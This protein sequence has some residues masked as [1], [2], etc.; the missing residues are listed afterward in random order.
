MTG[1]PEPPGDRMQPAADLTELRAALSERSRADHAAVR[2]RAASRVATAVRALPPDLVG[3]PFLAALAPHRFSR[4][5]FLDALHRL[6]APSPRSSPAV[7]LAATLR[8]GAH[9]DLRALLERVPGRPHLR[10]VLEEL[11]LL[12]AARAL[13]WALDLCQTRGLGELA[14]LLA[15]TA[16]HQRLALPLRRRCLGLARQLGA[17]SP[18]LEPELEHLLRG[19][20]EL[21]LD[22]ARMAV[23][24]PA[25][26]PLVADLLG[27]AVTSGGDRAQALAWLALTPALPRPM[28]REVLAF[29]AAN[30]PAGLWAA[31]GDQ[32]RADL[33]EHLGAALVRR[34][35]TAGGSRRVQLLRLAMPVS[36]QRVAAACLDLIRG[37]DPA[38]L[39]PATALLGACGGASDLAELD[40]LGRR[41][42]SPGPVRAAARHAAV[43]IRERTAERGG[44]LSVVHEGGLALHSQPGADP[45][46]LALEPRTDRGRGAPSIPRTDP[47]G[48]TNGSG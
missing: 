18:A 43:A 16:R 12:A 33:D 46:G 21:A 20:P 35:A 2:D 39:D 32:V 15:H 14:P 25:L 4:P 29:A 31:I 8:D 37:G 24:M 10:Q 47:G 34:A 42:F 5:D 3:E 6:G 23:A 1:D 40:R 11:L 41:L 48:D 27:Q 28:A 30:A 19:H 9:P 44:A 36:A 26:H 22:A 7:R 45:G 13:P 17:P 38:C